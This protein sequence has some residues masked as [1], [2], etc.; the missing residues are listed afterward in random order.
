MSGDPSVYDV[1]E[2]LDKLEEHCT[3]VD[4]LIWDDIRALRL[5]IKRLNEL[6]AHT[7]RIMRRMAE[8]IR[9]E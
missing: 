8:V 4:G 6:L 9:Y 2:R 3:Y 1:I 7:T 5:E